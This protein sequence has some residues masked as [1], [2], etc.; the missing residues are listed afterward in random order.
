[1]FQI[2]RAVVA[3]C[4][5]PSAVERCIHLKSA[6]SFK[7]MRYINAL[8]IVIKHAIFVHCIKSVFTKGQNRS[9]DFGLFVANL[10]DHGIIKFYHLFLG[11][12]NG[13]K[14]TESN[15]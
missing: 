8:T 14:L 10:H 12:T 5:R 13:L 3:D 2:C 7:D 1:M 6:S 11:L 4:L 9:R 15:H